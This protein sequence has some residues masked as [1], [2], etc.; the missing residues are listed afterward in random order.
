[1]NENTFRFLGVEP[2]FLR[3]SS[4]TSAVWPGGTSISKDAR[5]LLRSP[6]MRV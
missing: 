1:M 4:C 6:V 5:T 3:R 2:V